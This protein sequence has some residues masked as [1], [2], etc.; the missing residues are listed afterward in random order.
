MIHNA[1][2]SINASLPLRRWMEWIENSWQW[3]A[4]VGILGGA[5]ALRVAGLDAGLPLDFNQ[6]EVSA[7]ELSLGINWNDPNPHLFY[8]G[9]L[10]YYILKSITASFFFLDVVLMGK[11][12]TLSEYYLICRLTIVTF[13]VATVYFAYVFGKLLVNPLVGLFTAAF[14]ALSPL[15]IHLSHYSTVDP[16]M[17]FWTAFSFVCMA[18]FIRGNRLGLYIAGIGV[19]MAI[20]T[21]YNAALLLIPIFLISYQCIDRTS[22]PLE[23]WRVV[24]L[25]SLVLLNA[26]LFIG[27]LLNKARLLILASSWTVRGEIQPVYIQLIDKILGFYAGIMVGGLVLILGIAIG[28]R[29]SRSLVQTFTSR[30]FLIPMVL[31]SAMF[32]LFSP[33][34]FL[35][36]P[37]FVRDFFFQLNK[38]SSGGLVGFAPGSRSFTAIADNPPRIDPFVYI[39]YLENEWGSIVFVLLFIGAWALW[40]SNRLAFLPIT[41][42]IGIVLIS[43]YSLQYQPDRYLYPILIIFC[44][45]AGLGVWFVAKTFLRFADGGK[46][47]ITIFALLIL[48]FLPPMLAA[49]NKVRDEFLLLDTRNLALE[50]IEKNVPPDSY[51]L[52]EWGTPEIERASA[53]YRVHYTGFPFEEATL[54]EWKARGVGVVL[55]SSERVD[56]YRAHAA[57]FGDVIAEY[58]R[59]R[60]DGKLVQSFEPSS[61]IKGPPIY[62]YLLD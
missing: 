61:G 40:R 28:W 49:F 1:L 41:S 44:V 58:D 59:L 42:L 13:G 25:Y 37:E 54:A 10:T 16:I 62:I 34:I 32:A 15:A 43:T 46:S 45:L 12:T 31:A 35:D 11:V 21:K 14:F 7:V 29:W 22:K 6:D 23:K 57:D 36:Y 50:W 33:F 19:G 20:T 53:A 9:S 56:F 27:I 48:M 2:G 24:V 52:S 17:G 51:I 60:K 30:L 26:L 4:L 3:I 18:S 55:T 8:Y 5:L 39:N 47:R 38:Y